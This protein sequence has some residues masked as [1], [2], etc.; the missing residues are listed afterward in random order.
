MAWKNK[1][2]ETFGWLWMW[3]DLSLSR[4]VTAS[5]WKHLFSLKCVNC[6]GFSFGCCEVWFCGQCSACAKAADCDDD[7]EAYLARQR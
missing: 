2:I 3:W 4:R 7:G 6:R 1:Q 5:E